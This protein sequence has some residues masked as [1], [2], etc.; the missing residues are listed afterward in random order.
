MVFVAGI[1]MHLIRAVF[2]E[3]V[4]SVFVSYDGASLLWE[5]MTE[6]PGNANAIICLH[7]VPQKL[8][9]AI[10]KL[11]QASVPRGLCPPSEF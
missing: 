8:S 10:L 11:E 2:L 5:G 7:V 1:E 3:P 6:N 9:P 4:K